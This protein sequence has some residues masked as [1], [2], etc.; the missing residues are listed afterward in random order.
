MNNDFYLL[1]NSTLTQ[2]RFIFAVTMGK[3][4]KKGKSKINGYS[5]EKKC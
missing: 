2:L 1:D 4:N 5:R 3:H